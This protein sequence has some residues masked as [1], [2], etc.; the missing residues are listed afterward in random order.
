MNTSTATTT[1]QI[2]QALSSGSLAP[3]LNT[4]EVILNLLSAFLLSLLIAIVYKNTHRGLS[5]SQTFVMTL[6]LS[7]IVIAGVMMIIGNNL[8]RAFGAFGAFSLIRFRTAIKDAKDMGFIFLVLAVGMAIGTGNYVIAL[9]LAI[10][11][12]AVI[13]ILT[14][15]NFGSIRKFDYVLSFHYD[16]RASNENAYKSVFDKYLKS[17]NVL[18]MKAREAG[19]I[20]TMSFNIKLISEHDSS[21]FVSELE[22][23]SGVSDVSLIAAKND[24]EY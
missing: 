8:A 6:I 17:N 23:V 10:I 13:F 3:G 9:A 20:L 4:T 12:L 24:V 22:R 15:V 2:L 21:A 1:L 7:G 18:Y 5:Y 14:K 11:S 19:H 16:T